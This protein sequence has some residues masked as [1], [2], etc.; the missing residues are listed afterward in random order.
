ME[1]A[2]VQYAFT[3][4][5]PSSKPVNSCKASNKMDMLHSEGAFIP[6]W[7]HVYSCLMYKSVTGVDAT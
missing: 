3:V 1:K 2:L 7:Q 5:G 6:A 4:W